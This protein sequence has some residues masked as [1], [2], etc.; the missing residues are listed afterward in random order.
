MDPIQS[1]FLPSPRGLLVGYLESTT[2]RKVRYFRGIESLV[3]CRNTTSFVPG[4]Q[5]VRVQ[6]PVEEVSRDH[7]RSSK[8]VLSSV[9][10]QWLM[11]IFLVYRGELL[12][13]TCHWDGSETRNDSDDNRLSVWVRVCI[14]TSY[15]RLGLWSAP[16]QFWVSGVGRNF[17]VVYRYGLMSR[18]FCH[19]GSVL[20][21]DVL[22]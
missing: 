5:M 11:G 6:K 14:D 10:V 18:G 8:G 9:H 7:E 4:I 1:S 21:L 17:E 12:S 15:W 19:N 22:D 2:K 13:T 20:L 16:V 3:G